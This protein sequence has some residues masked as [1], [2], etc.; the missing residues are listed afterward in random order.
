[1][2][3]QALADYIAAARKK[4]HA[5]DQIQ[6]DLTGAGWDKRLVA[7]ALK[8]AADLPVPAPAPGESAEA[9]R[10]VVQTRSTRGL[11]YIIMFIALAV[12]GVALGSI[13][14]SSVNSLFGSNDSILSSGG[15]VPFAASALVVGFPILAY[16]FL[17]LM[18]AELADPALRHDPSRKRAIQLTLVVTF[19]VGLGNVIFF[20]Y[21]LMAGNPT[22]NYNSFGS[23]AANSLLGNFVHL[24]ITLAI[25][26]GIFYYYW[27]DEHEAR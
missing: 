3:H 13:L 24:V 12:S 14:H 27:R 5:D 1:M 2:S 9:P 16:L 21:S 18:K 23:S 8:P 4:G 26:G 15:V 22:D 17:R 19:L 10:P 25:A 7:A 6:V 20:V 11:E